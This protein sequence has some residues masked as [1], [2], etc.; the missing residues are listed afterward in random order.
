MH[1][2]NMYP[3][4]GRLYR[5]ADR[6]MNPVPGILFASQ[7]PYKALARKPDKYNH[8]KPVKQG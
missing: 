6:T 1:T 7:R 3:I 5:P 2:Q 8:A 4:Q